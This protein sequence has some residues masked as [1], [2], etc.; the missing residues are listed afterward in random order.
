MCASDELCKKPE[1]GGAEAEAAAAAAAAD[2]A[3]HAAVQ[4]ARS[5]V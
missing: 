3:V 4:R 1:G 2:Q 5:M